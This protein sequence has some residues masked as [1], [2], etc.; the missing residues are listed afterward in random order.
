M[1]DGSTALHDRRPQEIRILRLLVSGRIAATN[2]VKN[3]DRVQFNRMRVEAGGFVSGR[4]DIKEVG[5]DRAD[6]GE[7]MAHFFCF[8]TALRLAMGADVLTI[9]TNPV[10][11]AGKKPFKCS[12]FVRQHFF[13]AAQ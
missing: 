11:T 10:T 13:D 7:S 6:T 1:A 2:Q 4:A 9:K 3:S 8:A 5:D 12:G